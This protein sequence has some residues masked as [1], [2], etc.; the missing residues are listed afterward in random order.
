M[1][2]IMLSRPYQPVF[3]AIVLVFDMS[4]L[5]FD[6]QGWIEHRQVSRKRFTPRQ[7]CVALTSLPVLSEGALFCRES[8]TS[9]IDLF[10][11]IAL[12]APSQN[13]HTAFS[14]DFILPLFGSAQAARPKTQTKP[15]R[16]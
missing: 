1:A 7:A 10:K 16:S 13:S 12:T 9:A 3:R 5:V 14:V 8:D 4:L 15:G 11:W 6:S 2:L